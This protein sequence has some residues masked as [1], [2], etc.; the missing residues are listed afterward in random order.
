LGE[1]LKNG[2]PWGGSLHEKSTITTKKKQEKDASKGILGKK[3][4]NWE[5]GSGEKDAGKKLVSIRRPRAF[6]RRDKI[7]LGE[8]GV[9]K[10]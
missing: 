9:Q 2:S 10:K 3:G 6:E 7:I 5:I 4:G 8:A 1:E